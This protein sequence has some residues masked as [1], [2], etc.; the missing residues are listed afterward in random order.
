MF[1][2]SAKPPADGA[3]TGGNIELFMIAV[4]APV[5]VSAPMVLSPVMVLAVL[6]RGIVA[7]SMEGDHAVPVDTGTPTGGHTASMAGLIDG[8]CQ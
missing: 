1:H 6:V 7:G 4:N 8:S 5:T 2:P 3:T